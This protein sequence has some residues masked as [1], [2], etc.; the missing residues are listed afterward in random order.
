M[1]LKRLVD[2]DSYAGFFTLGSTEQIALGYSQ[3]WALVCMLMEKHR[4]EFFD[5]IKY[6]R[7]PANTDKTRWK[8][9]YAILLDKLG[10][11]AQNLEAEW[12]DYIQALDIPDNIKKVL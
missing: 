3:S 9:R 4:L 1:S 5:Y 11:S 12:R 6:I 7:D 2:F 8:S 10:I